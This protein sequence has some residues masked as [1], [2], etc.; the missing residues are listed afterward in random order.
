MN[1]LREFRTPG[2]YFIAVDEESLSCGVYRGRVDGVSVEQVR[3]SGVKVTGVLFLGNAVQPISGED[4]FMLLPVRSG[5]IA[6][7]YRSGPEGDRKVIQLNVRVVADQFPVFIRHS[8]EVREF[9]KNLSE[10]D[11]KK[12]RIV[13]L[14]PDVLRIDTVGARVAFPHARV[15]QTVAEGRKSP[16]VPARVRAVDLMGRPGMEHMSQNPVYMARVLLRRLDFKGME[17]LPIDYNLSR[18]DVEF[19]R[20]FIDV[21]YKNERGSRELTEN[22][23][24]IGQLMKFYRIIDLII[25]MERDQLDRE[26]EAGLDQQVVSNLL[27][28]L[29]KQRQRAKTK[30]QEIAFWELEYRLAGKG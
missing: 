3:A 13:V 21:M 6:V 15:F 18:E 26:V 5:S 28:F 9:L 14:G 29:R 2:G 23:E 27:P 8:P 25:R 10:V 4:G 30:D 11:R 17:R 7:P 1:Q 24:R 19:I 20:A 12:F 16:T 22:H